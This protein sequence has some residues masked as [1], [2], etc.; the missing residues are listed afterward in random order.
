MNI[1]S[2]TKVLKKMIFLMFGFT[3][4]NIKFLKILHIFKFLRWCLFFLLNVE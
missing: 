3:R 2:L 4:E 1:M